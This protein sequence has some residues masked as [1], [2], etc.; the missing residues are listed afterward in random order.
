VGTATAS[1]STAGASSSSGGGGAR[2][3]RRRL[4]VV[5]VTNSNCGIDDFVVL[6][7]TPDTTTADVMYKVYIGPTFVRPLV[8]IRKNY[9]GSNP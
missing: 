9:G 5:N 2:R 4:L 6:N 8:F 3:R 1:V 7:V